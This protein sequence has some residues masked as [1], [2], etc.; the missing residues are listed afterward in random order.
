MSDPAVVSDSHGEW[1]ELH[2][3]GEDTVDLN[4]WTIRDSERDVHVITG[5]SAVVVPPGAYFVLGRDGDSSLNGGYD[6]DYIYDNVILSNN[7]DEIVLVDPEST[8]VD[9]VAYRG[10]GWPIGSGRSME[11]IEESSDNSLGD[12]WLPATEYFGDG[13]MGT[14]GE[15]NSASSV[16]TG[17]DGTGDGEE[18]S[19]RF[20]LRNYP[21][22][23][24][25]ST[26]VSFSGAMQV[27]RDDLSG[28][29]AELS[30]TLSVYDMRGRMVRQLWMGD[31]TGEMNVVWDGT[32][33]RGTNLPPGIYVVRLAGG[34][35][36]TQRKVV[37]L[38]R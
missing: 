19:D 12:F 5:E 38:G 16:G 18:I 36:R 14:P 29:P 33:D 9:S 8:L 30:A 26:T 17:E 21:N 7:E 31:L 22:P 32:D 1:I 3:T 11:F 24:R 37:Y 23:F 6:A 13:D 27:S 2:N 25:E 34:L 20:I 28:I 4:G 15:R 35:D 10:E